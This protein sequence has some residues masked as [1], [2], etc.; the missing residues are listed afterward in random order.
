MTL[1]QLDYVLTVAKYRSFSQAANK[2]SLSQPALSAQISKL[3]SELGFRLF[4]RSSL[5]LS[6]T[7]DAKEF[8]KRAED[9]VTSAK[10]LEKFSATKTNDFDG[11]LRLGIIPTLSPFLVPLFSKQLSQNY[12]K[13][14]LDITEMI[15]EEVIKKVRSGELDAGLISTPMNSFGLKSEPLF[16]EKF[17]FYSSDN[18]ANA[19]LK[20]EEVNI[21]D[22]WLLEEGN[23][24]RDQVNDFCNIKSDKRDKQLVYRC[25]SIDSLIRMVDNYGGFTILPELTTISLNDHQEMNITPIAKKAREIGIITRNATDKARYIEVLKTYILKNIPNPMLQRKGLHIVDPMLDNF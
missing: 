14:R 25:N 21:S 19:S 18:Y 17:Y 16:Y 13:F 20:I 4:D 1:A 23:C 12:P 7:E 15:T 2:L 22:L 9:L 10:A 24:F 6:T 8:L 11:E 3:E 5:P